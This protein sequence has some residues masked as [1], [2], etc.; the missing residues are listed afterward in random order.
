M[1]LVMKF[2]PAT[3][4]RIFH[5]GTK[6]KYEL[7][8]FGK[9][10]LEPGEQVTFV[11][12]SGAEYD[13]ARKSWGFYATP[14]LNDRLTRFGLRGVLIKSP[15]DRFYVLLVEKGQEADFQAYLD[16]EGHSIVSWLDTPEALEKL[17]RKAKAR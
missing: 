12:P 1:D 14:S 4:P 2:T 3:P 6:E 9:V 8:D 17:D 11:T 16:D 10:A 5:A 15:N 13:L 7:K